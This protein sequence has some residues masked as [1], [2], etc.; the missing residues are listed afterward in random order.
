VASGRYTVTFEA[1]D[2]RVSATGV[3]QPGGTFQVGTFREGDGAVLGKHR[4]AITPPVPDGDV[5]RPK[6]RVHPKYERFASS[7]LEVTVTRGPNKVTL[8]LEPAKR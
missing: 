4:V 1:Q 8:E 5:V 7:E 2:Q 6:S 3:V